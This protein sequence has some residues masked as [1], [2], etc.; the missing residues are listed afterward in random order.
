MGVE[1]FRL[2][3]HRLTL[4]HSGCGPHPYPGQG[5]QGRHHEDGGSQRTDIELKLTADNGDDIWA[6]SVTTDSTITRAW[7]AKH[8]E[9]GHSA[10]YQGKGPE[11]LMKKFDDEMR[12][13]GEVI[14]SSG[15]PVSS[16]TLITNTPESLEF[17]G[18]RAREILGPDVELHIQLKP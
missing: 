1:S 11:F 4:T 13:Y 3:R 9:G 15:N 8:T 10:L 17:L 7:D 12:V 6:D 5:Q 16:L 2:G 18:Q 14:R